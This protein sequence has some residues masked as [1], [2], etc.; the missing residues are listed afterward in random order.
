MGTVGLVDADFVGWQ[1]NCVNIVRGNF[2]G[3]QLGVVN[4]AKAAEGL[5]LGLVNYVENMNGLQIGA[6]NIIRQGG[7]LPVFPIINWSF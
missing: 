5:Q 6:V 1:D 7:M 4:Y 3:F 2:K